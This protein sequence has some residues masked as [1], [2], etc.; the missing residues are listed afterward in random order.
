MT[1][2]AEYYSKELED[3]HWL[4]YYKTST[5]GPEITFHSPEH[6][7]IKFKTKEKSDEY[8]KQY[9]IEQGWNIISEQ[10]PA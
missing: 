1:L 7:N 3:G 4:P 8:A 10:A 5:I 9:C 2:N 6:L